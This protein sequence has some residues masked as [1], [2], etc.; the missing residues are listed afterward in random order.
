MVY[1]AFEVKLP[2]WIDEFMKDRERVY[3]TERERMALVIELARMNVEKG[4]GGPFAAAIF[5]MESDRLIA[6][7]VNLVTH[8]NC[9]VLHAEIVA[10]MM[11]QKITGYYDLGG[12]GIH[13]SELVTSTEPCAMCLGAVPWAG[14]SRLV[15]GAREDDARNIGFDEGEK[16]AYWQRGLESRG[17]EVV[18]DICREDA[19]RVLK[20][21]QELGG[22]IYNAASLK[23]GE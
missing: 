4:T 13:S 7:G 22:E 15:C 11:A 6:P 14:V 12:E 10:I 1:P 23:D 18:R 17:I 5:D 16:P 21:Y 20:Q 3:P 8:S 19:V 2:G 9:S